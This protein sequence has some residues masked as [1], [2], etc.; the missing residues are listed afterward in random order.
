VLL[1]TTVVAVISTAET[2]GTTAAAAQDFL[3]C[4]ACNK[5]QTFI[6]INATTAAGAPFSEKDEA[7][8]IFY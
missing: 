4:N 1:T 3:A 8:H 2:T 6:I 7:V 5:I